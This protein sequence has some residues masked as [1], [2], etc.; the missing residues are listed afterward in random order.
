MLFRSGLYYNWNRYYDPN[1]GRYIRADPIGQRSLFNLSLTLGRVNPGQLVTGYWNHLFSYVDNHP[2]GLTDTTGLSSIEDLLQR[3]GRNIG[4]KL[5]RASMGAI[6]AVECAAKQ[7][8][9]GRGKIN[10]T[11][12]DAECLS[13]LNRI[14][15]DNPEILAGMEF[16][17]AGIVH[18]ISA[19]SAECVRIVND[20]KF[21]RNCSGLSCLTTGKNRG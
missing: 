12:A 17:A 21:Q 4:K 5:N 9:P 16:A 10:R 13:I 6:L 8:R 15:K 20:E 18:V 1:T 3:M 14:T 11:F 2:T 7:C 19:C